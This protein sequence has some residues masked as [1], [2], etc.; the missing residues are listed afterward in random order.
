MRMAALALLLAAAAA[1]NSGDNVVV[2]GIGESS[3]TPLIQ[4]DNINSVISGRA[5]LFDADGGAAGTSEVVIISD[6]PQLCDRLKQHPDYFRNP[7]ETYLALILFLPPTNHLGTFLPGRAGDEGTD[8]EIIGVKDTGT[9]VP[10][11]ETTK[12]VAPF[13]ALQLGGY[14]AL[15]DWSEQAGGESKGSFNLLYAAPQA[16]NVPGARFPFYGKFK[17]SVC[18][19]LDGILLP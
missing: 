1:C 12:P 11:F 18:P 7:P 5:R 2:G 19:T 17:S 16:L 10:P 4:F 13:P 3:I 9:P 14:I 6:R 8:S 15:S